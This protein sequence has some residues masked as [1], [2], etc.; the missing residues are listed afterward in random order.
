MFPRISDPFCSR[1][2][3]WER[4]DIY[5]HDDDKKIFDVIKGNLQVLSEATDLKQLVFQ[6]DGRIVKQNANQPPQRTYNQKREINKFTH[7]VKEYFKVNSFAEKEAREIRHTIHEAR[8]NLILL[9]GFTK[10]KESDIELIKSSSY[11][12]ENEKIESSGTK[13]LGEDLIVNKFD[14]IK[15]EIKAT[16]SK[17]SKFK[18]KRNIA[19][20]AIVASMVFLAVG[21]VVGALFFPPVALLAIGV[22]VIAFPISAFYM[23]RF[24]EQY[25]PAKFGGL[26]N[27]LKLGALDRYKKHYEE[28]EI[29]EFQGFINKLPEDKRNLLNHS[30]KFM[31]MHQLYDLEKKLGQ[32]RLLLTQEKDEQKKLHIEREIISQRQLI[33]DLRESL[34]LPNQETTTV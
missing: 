31:H 29:K 12:L 17:I 2:N 4:S 15:K 6:S 9:S 13:V 10:S 25:F 23:H 14:E 30:D 20:A 32:Q 19:R 21:S 5:K 11:L 28:S 27:I 24:N 16:K 3:E 1:Y 22:F 18:M 8:E 33:L 7:F 26:S 34:K